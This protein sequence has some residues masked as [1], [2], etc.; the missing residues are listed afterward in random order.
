MSE[1]IKL[2]V[3]EEH[4]LGYINP[5][6]RMANVLHASILRGSPILGSPLSAMEPILIENKA[7]RLASTKDFDD[8]RVSMSGFEN[9]EEY[10]YQH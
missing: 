10:E 4:T 6:S 8:Y 5:N 3:I 9:V 1:K 2:V 7:V